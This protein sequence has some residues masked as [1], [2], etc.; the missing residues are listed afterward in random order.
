MQGLSGKEIDIYVFIQSLY[1][2]G[3]KYGLAPLYPNCKKE[4]LI[5]RSLYFLSGI[6]GTFVKI[7]GF[8]N[9]T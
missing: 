9:Y 5:M 1:R 8:F 6:L 3:G 4:G 2:I 7:N